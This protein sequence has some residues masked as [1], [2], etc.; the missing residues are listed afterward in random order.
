MA[1]VKTGCYW[2]N[3][4]VTWNRAVTGNYATAANA[5]AASWS[6]ST[7]VNM[8]MSY[9]SNLKASSKNKGA[10]GYDGYAVWNCPILNVT[11]SA[12]WW[13]N[14]HYTTGMAVNKL[15]A[16]AVHEFGHTLGLNH[17]TSNKQMMYKCPACVYNTNGFYTPQ[18][19]D[20]KGMNAIY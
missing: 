9:S 16:I 4:P 13:F 3:N 19:D 6:S 20:K 2:P 5:A 11:I 17:V 10:D 12:E 15:R 18:D 1:Y 14:T 7:D 8:T